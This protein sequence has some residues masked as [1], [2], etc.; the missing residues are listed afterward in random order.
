MVISLKTVGVQDVASQIRVSRRRTGSTAPN[1]TCPQR[2]AQNRGVYLVLP[3]S[4]RHGFNLGLSRV[5]N[6][7]SNY[8]AV[9]LTDS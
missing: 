6:H 8:V 3:N 4:C 7:G 9:E 1:G 5:G 2:D